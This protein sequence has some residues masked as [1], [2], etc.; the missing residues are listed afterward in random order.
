MI[1][2]AARKSAA[3]R[4]RVEE[5]VQRILSLKER[6]EFVPLRYRAQVKTRISRQIEK[7]R[8]SVVEVEPRVLTI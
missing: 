7:L 4:R 1:L 5:S 8:K 6:I 3:L 2:S